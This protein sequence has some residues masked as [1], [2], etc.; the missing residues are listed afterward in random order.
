MK[1]IIQI[2]NTYNKLIFEYYQITYVD[3][4]FLEE[5]MKELVQSRVVL[6]W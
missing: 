2:R 6:K 1:R 5:I 4:Q 3:F